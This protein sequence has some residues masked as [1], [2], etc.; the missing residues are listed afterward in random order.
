MNPLP[1]KITYCASVSLLSILLASCGMFKSASESSGASPQ[2]PGQSP[3]AFPE[4]IGL[5]PSLPSSPPLFPGADSDADI[6]QRIIDNAGDNYTYDRPVLMG[7]LIGDSHQKVKAL[8]GDEAEQYIME[9]P[10]DPVRV[11]DYI[12]FQVGLDSQGFVKFISIESEELDPGLGGIRIGSSVDAI[13]PLIGEPNTDTQYV[14]AYTS[15]SAVLKLDIDP[16]E[17]LVKSIKLFAD[18]QES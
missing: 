14:L 9:H 10:V 8:Y 7:L 5:T 11:L 12:T 6:N 3:P 15:S 13:R 2:I 17:E 4:G 1:K 18:S 16:A